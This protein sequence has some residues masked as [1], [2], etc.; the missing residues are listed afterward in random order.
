MTTDGAADV[1]AEPFWRSGVARFRELRV[2][3]YGIVASFLALFI[4]LSFAS[5][6]FFTKT[7]L[8]NIL[9]QNAPVAIIACAQTIVIIGGGFDLSVGA[10]F[11]LGGVVAA[12]TVP[13]IGSGSRS[14][15][16]PCS[17]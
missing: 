14:W 6:V 5:N 12:Q 16:A 13:H 10:M 9:D 4:G 1:S 3:D 17:A 2:R 15:W 8:L 11:A 7:N